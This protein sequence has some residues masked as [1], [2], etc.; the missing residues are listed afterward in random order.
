[1]AKVLIA[2]A[3][4]YIGRRLVT[5]LVDEGHQV[6]GLVRSIKQC[7]EWRL[8]ARARNCLVFANVMF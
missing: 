5:S 6:V 7:R 4:G 2:G 8:N 1:M 3:N